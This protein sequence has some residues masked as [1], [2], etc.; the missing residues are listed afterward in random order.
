MN[1]EE[2]KAQPGPAHYKPPLAAINPLYKKNVSSVFASG[3]PR[4]SPSPKTKIRKMKHKSAYVIPKGKYQAIAQAAAIANNG[5]FD[6]DSEDPDEV[7]GPGSY[8]ELS[9]FKPP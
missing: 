5:V 1:Q 4:S 8:Q 9:S 7:P 3:V 6:E 2:I